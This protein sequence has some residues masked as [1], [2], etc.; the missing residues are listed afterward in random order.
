[1]SKIC[2]IFAAAR[3]LRPATPP[4]VCLGSHCAW[5]DA[6]PTP[7]IVPAPPPTGRCG[8]TK[9]NNFPDPAASGDPAPEDPRR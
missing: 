5:W 1:V 7:P 4:G 9:G 6:Y 8:I 3:L 2:P